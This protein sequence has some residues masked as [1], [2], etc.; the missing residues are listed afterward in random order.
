MQ[1]GESF[2]IFQDRN[3]IAWGQQWKKRIEESLDAVTFLIPIVSPAFFKSP[4]CREEMERFLKREEDLGRTDL[5]LPVY[6]VEV[7][8]LSDEVKREK[9]PL[10]KAIA[11]RQYADWREL[12]FEPFTSP[13]VGKRL[14][15]LARQVVEALER[16]QSAP[17]QSTSNKSTNASFPP[18][19]AQAV[20]AGSLA[21]ASTP[22][23]GPASK[24]EPPLLVVDALHRGDYST[25]TEAIKVA[26]AGTRLLVRPGLYKEGI[27]IDK[28]VEIIGDGELGD[29]VIEASV[30]D[31]VLF[32]ASMGRIANLTLRQTGDGERYCVDIAQGRLDLEECDITSHGLACVAIHGGADPRVR[33]NRIH[34]GRRGGG[35]FVYEESRGTLEDNEIFANAIAGVEIKAGSNPT[36]RRNRIYHGKSAGVSFGRPGR[37][38]WRTMKYSPTHSQAWRS[39]PPATQPCAETAFTM[40]SRMASSFGITAEEYW[41]TMKYSPI[42]ARA[43]RL[44]PVAT[45]PCTEIAFRITPTK[46]FGFT[47]K[48][49][50]YLRRTTSV[51]MPEAHGIS[52]QT[53][54]QT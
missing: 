29:V 53:P 40:A 27:V 48:A 30:E 31:T 2:D 11:S 45:Q 17:S 15:Q 16:S 20:Q 47:T 3:D 36:L 14:A 44:G 13:E 10:A 38:R 1:T 51:E 42:H 6:Y 24:T 26:R 34:D 25:L 18:A 9:D 19:E 43:L 28:P 46:P 35:I 4:P 54:R 22:S 8:T 7:A 33:R 12:R 49:P 50:A 37:E 5:I 23:R 52:H 21:E 39:R 41:R 32:R